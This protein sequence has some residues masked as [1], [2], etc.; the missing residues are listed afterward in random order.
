MTR[1]LTEE[2][3]RTAFDRAA[4]RVSTGDLASMGEADALHTALELF[5]RLRELRVA[6]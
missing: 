2:Q 6:H 1:M 4:F 5:A 3:C